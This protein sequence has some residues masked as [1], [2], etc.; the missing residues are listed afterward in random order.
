MAF[1]NLGTYTTFAIFK[2]ISKVP[3]GQVTQQ[4]N[5]LINEQIDDLAQAAIV[6]S[7]LVARGFLDSVYHT[8]LQSSEG[9][10]AEAFG[11]IDLEGIDAVPG[12]RLRLYDYAESV[13]I[14]VVKSDS[15]FYSL[16]SLFKGIWGNDAIYGHMATIKSV[17]GDNEFRIAVERGTNKAVSVYAITA[18]TTDNPAKITIDF[19]VGGNPWGATLIG[20]YLFIKDVLG[21]TS[22]NGLHKV[23]AFVTPATYSLDVVGNSAYTS[24]GSVHKVPVQNLSYLRIPKRVADSDYIDLPEAYAPIAE[25]QLTIALSTL[26]QKTPPADVTE[27]VANFVKSQGASVARAV[28]A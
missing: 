19:G 22:V 15:E 11:M 12:E 17:G 24:G 14:P 8:T 21:T 20:Q 16:K 18:A 6:N 28:Q 26:I 4:Q 9:E 3:V 5:L 25:D 13:F 1:K 10:F 23:T 2:S 27:R 7:R